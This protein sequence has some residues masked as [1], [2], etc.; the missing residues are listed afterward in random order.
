MEERERHRRE[1]DEGSCMNGERKNSEDNFLKCVFKYVINVLGC[2][3]GGECV[4]E[5]WGKVCVNGE[6]HWRKGRDT[7]EKNTHTH[8]HTWAIVRS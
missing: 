4:E 1:K 7:G 2:V 6:N 8:T 3:W 5:R